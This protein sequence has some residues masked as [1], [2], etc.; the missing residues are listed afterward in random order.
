MKLTPL[1]SVFLRLSITFLHF[2]LGWVVQRLVIF[3]RPFCLCVETTSAYLLLWCIHISITLLIPLFKFLLDFDSIS[4]SSSQRRDVQKIHFCL[5]VFMQEA[6]VFW[7][8]IPLKVFDTQLGAKGMEDIGE[9][10]HCLVPFLS[11]CGPSHVLIIIASNKVI[12][13]LQS[14]HKKCPSGYG[15]KHTRFLHGCLLTVGFPPIFDMG[16]KFK[17][18]KS[19]LLPIGKIIDP[20]ITF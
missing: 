6:M 16:N 2:Q 7:S 9:L 12:L 15:G 19:Y 5:D 11:Q 14:I 8:Q 18:G 4:I 3:A 13:L 20:K 1:P 10:W 17:D